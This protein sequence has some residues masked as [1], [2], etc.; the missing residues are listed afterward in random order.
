MR[1]WLGKSNVTSKA[2][3]GQASLRTRGA[4]LDFCFSS[5]LITISQAEQKQLLFLGEETLWSGQSRMWQKGW[6]WRRLY[7][8]YLSSPVRPEIEGTISRPAPCHNRGDQRHG[9][10]LPPHLLSYSRDSLAGP[11]SPARGERLAKQRSCRWPVTLRCG[12]AHSRAVATW[13]VPLFPS[14]IPR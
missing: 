3:K 13:R 4:G 7:V 2:R 14:Q 10:H 9:W 12:R 11:P 8:K 6:C 5:C 1:A